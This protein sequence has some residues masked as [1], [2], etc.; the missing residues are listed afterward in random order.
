MGN[1]KF[2]ADA[3]LLSL[4]TT[5]DNRETSIFQNYDKC[6]GNLT[7]KMVSIHYALK[8]LVSLSPYCFC[9]II[10]IIIYFIPSIWDHPEKKKPTNL[11]EKE[12]IT[13]NKDLPLV[14]GE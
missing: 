7:C 12:K 8:T 9:N 13:G 1:I 4:N 10:V 3:G 14:H 11:P 5:E 2:P 6:M